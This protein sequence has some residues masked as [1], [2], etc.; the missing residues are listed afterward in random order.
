MLDHTFSRATLFG[1][2]PTGH[3]VFVKCRVTGLPYC[4]RSKFRGQIT[5]F[6]R[7]RNHDRYHQREASVRRL[8][9]EAADAGYSARNSLLVSAAL[10]V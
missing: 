6:A 3:S 1:W 9:Y 7:L 2:R 8:A 10:K 5:G 4:I